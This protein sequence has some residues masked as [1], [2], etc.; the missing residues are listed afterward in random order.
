[1]SRFRYS[2]MRIGGETVAG[3]LHCR[4]RREVT[5][6][7]LQMG[8]HPIAVEPAD[9]AVDPQSGMQSASHRWRNRVR[10]GDLAVLTRQMAS[11]LKAGLTL[12]DVLTTVRSQCAQRRLR[13]VLEDIDNRIVRDA[14]T[15]AEA[16]DEHPH[17]FDAVY[18]GL[19]R[20]GEE[21]G[22]LA[23]VLDDLARYLSRS[24]RL[25]GQ[26]LGAFVYPIFLVVVGVSA[27]VV[28][29]TWV[30]PKFADLFESFGQ[31][32]PWIT[33]CLMATSSFLANWWWLIAIALLAALLSAMGALRQRDLRLRL[34][35]ARLRLP[36]FGPMLLKLEIARIAR[37]LGTLLDSGVR[38]LDAL[39]ITAGTARNQAIHDT[40]KGTADGVAHGQTLAD[41]VER[42][43]LYP[44]MVINLI[45][46]GETTGEL[47]GM[48]GELSAIYEEEA[49]RAVNGA[50]KLLEPTLIVILG[51]V[52][53]GIVA[54]VILPI[55]Q[56]NAMVN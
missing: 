45:R 54:A 44:P 35:R 15:F 3:S 21:G 9:G 39:Q 12:C 14:I 43:G 23:E 36:V 40:F 50:V 33:K 29:M 34:D 6:R 52:I 28:L 4:D 38:I 53:A 42:A 19:V 41:S 30:I 2:A 11:L 25:R 7:L 56:M 51:L 27:V 16:L 20:S 55:F 31:D 1:V 18:R 5:T 48:L 37:T 26:V 10:S 49:E 17:V 32:L 13:T 46:T 22:N 47:P 24:A 8:C